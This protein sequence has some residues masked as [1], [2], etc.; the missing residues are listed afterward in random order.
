[1]SKAIACDCGTMFFQVADEEQ[2][3]SII[4]NAFVEI[5]G[6]DDIEDILNQNGW[7]YVQDG[8]TYYV[9]GEDSLRVAQM[10]D[11]VK[12]RRPLQDGVLNKDENKKML[13]LAEMIDSAIGQAPDDKSVIC[14]CISSPSVDGSIDSTYHE[15]RLKSMFTRLGW[16]VKVIEEGYA[17]VLSECPTMEEADGSISKF[18]GLGISFGAGRINCVLAYK[19]LPVIGMS[20]TRSGDWLDKQVSEQLGIPISQVTAKKERGIDLNNINIDDDFEFAL[21]AFYGSMLKYVFSHFS[22][23]F[24]EVKSDFSAPL[25]IVIAGGTSMPKG[26]CNKVTE[27]I[28]SMDLPFELKGVRSASDPQNAV[29]FGC[30]AQAMIT[31]KK[32]E[33]QGV[34]EEI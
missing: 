18:S 12:L 23:K 3:L 11:K 33:K 13:V 28:N 7:Q 14:T 19:A 16:N 15:A 27:V 30:L 10:F 6:V 22:K 25:E 5:S 17:V 21:D 9:I 31:R 26:F 1:M 4:R 2:N 20:T 8:S 29:V 24:E 34:T 32:L